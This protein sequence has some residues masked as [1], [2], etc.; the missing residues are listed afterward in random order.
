MNDTDGATN[1][2]LAHVDLRS[3]AQK[4]TYPHMVGHRA[5][6]ANGLYKGCLRRPEQI[7]FHFATTASCITF[8]KP[9]SFTATP[10]DTSLPSYQVTTDVLIGADGIK[11]P[12]RDAM[13][14]SLGIRGSIGV[15]DTQQ[16][17]YR[18]LIHK[19][20]LRPEDEDIRA[21]MESNQVVRWIGEKRHIIAYPVSNNTIYNLST[22]QPDANF[23]AATNATY[24][25]RGSK[26]AMMRVFRDFCPL[27][28]RM[29]GY[30]QDGER[31]VS[32]N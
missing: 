12:T 3:I 18:I 25:T 11:S 15:Q 31:C 2:E 13:L 4:Y 21:L 10:R 32:G 5:S 22:A 27:V 29:L 24:T 8:T 6:L 7:T 16:A 19:N 28:Q 9:P 14:L 26:E 1:T 30:V 17:A 20:Q 23:A